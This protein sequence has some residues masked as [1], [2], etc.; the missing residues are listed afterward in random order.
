MDNLLK[1]IKKSLKIRPVKKTATMSAL[2]SA[3]R[4]S[5]VK[6]ASTLTSGHQDNDPNLRN[7][8]KKTK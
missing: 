4:P 2:K 1:K 7:V 5:R 8:T 3:K 6:R